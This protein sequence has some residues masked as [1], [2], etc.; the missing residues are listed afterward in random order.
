MTT[1][2]KYG[3]TRVLPTAGLLLIVFLACFLFALGGL[4]FA[5]INASATPIWPVTGIALA[6]S[7]LWGRRMWPAIFL[8]AFLANLFTAGTPLTSFMIAVGNTLEAVVG[9]Y[10][11]ERWAGGRRTFETPSGVLIFAVVEG[12]IATPISASIGVEPADGRSGAIEPP[13]PDLDNMV[14]RQ[15]DRR[16]R[17]R[18]N[19]RI[20]GRARTKTF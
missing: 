4:H 13:R 15:F 18:A 10:I 3:A 2:D 6:A 12:L 11:L 1:A 14:A 5:S 17:G 8:G 7:L 16:A 20:V 19:D 9:A